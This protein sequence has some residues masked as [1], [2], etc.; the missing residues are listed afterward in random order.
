MFVAL[1]VV[2]K[3]RMYPKTVAILV[4][5]ATLFAGQT[6]Q[7]SIMYVSDVKFEIFPA[8]EVSQTPGTRVH[9][10]DFTSFHAQRWAQL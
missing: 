3:V 10:N 8:S 7:G 9:A 5:V 4:F 6:F 1:C 2:V